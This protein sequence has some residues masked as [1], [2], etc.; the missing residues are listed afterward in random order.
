MKT[1][2]IICIVGSLLA[3]LRTIILSYANMKKGG[4]LCDLFTQMHWINYVPV[5]NFV[6]LVVVYIHEFFHIKIK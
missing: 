1:I 5:I 2:L 4:N 3:I 6:G